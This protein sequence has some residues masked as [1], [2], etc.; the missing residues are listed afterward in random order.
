MVSQL[1]II[2]WFALRFIWRRPLQ[3]VVILAAQLLLALA[4]IVPILIM[5]S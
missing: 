4:S 2:A 5:E 3:T 1:P